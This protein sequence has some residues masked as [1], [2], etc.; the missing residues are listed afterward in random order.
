MA[1]G[2][3]IRLLSS[4]NVISSENLCYVATKLTCQCLLGNIADLFNI[5][6]KAGHAAAFA[7]DCDLPATHEMVRSIG[8][9]VIFYTFEL[10]TVFRV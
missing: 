9:Q 10:P 3:F 1:H 2:A 7:T 5:Q 8:M 4:F 6:L